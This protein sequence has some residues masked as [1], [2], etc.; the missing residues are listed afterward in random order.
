MVLNLD[1]TE[2]INDVLIITND[3]GSIICIPR[4]GAI[5][6]ELALFAEFEEVFPNGKP[7]V[8]ATHQQLIPTTEDRI[9][10]LESALSALMEVQ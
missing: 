3:D 8:V 6:S 5:E 9:T 1:K 7:I 4:E 10:A 2:L